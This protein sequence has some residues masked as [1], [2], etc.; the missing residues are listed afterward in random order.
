MYDQFWFLDILNI[1]LP[2]WLLNFSQLFDDENHIFSES[3]DLD[4][5]FINPTSILRTG[6]QCDISQNSIQ[7]SEDWKA[8]I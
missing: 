8:P 1:S 5:L 3:I 4:N 7:C 6:L 2:A